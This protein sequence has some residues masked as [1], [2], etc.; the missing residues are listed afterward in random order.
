MV[1]YILRALSVAQK[2]AN[3]ICEIAK[4]ICANEVGSPLSHFIVCVSHNFAS[5][6]SQP[7]LNHAVKTLRRWP[8]VA[9][10]KG[11][12]GQRCLPPHFSTNRL[13]VKANDQ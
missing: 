2:S 5:P 6:P 13:V 7:I 9:R 10:G 4:C 11:N 1:R 3:Q 12:F 8:L